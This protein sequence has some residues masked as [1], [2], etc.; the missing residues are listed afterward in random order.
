MSR[1]ARATPKPKV[2]KQMWRIGDWAEAA[3]VSRAKVFEWLAED[4]LKS[5]RIDGCRFILESPVEFA[6][7]QGEAA[8]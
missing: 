6:A 8:L 7:R 1:K 2:E 3:S 5:T 4:R